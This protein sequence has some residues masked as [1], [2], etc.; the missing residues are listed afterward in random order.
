MIFMTQHRRLI[1]PKDN[2][3][4]LNGSELQYSGEVQNARDS[5]IT[6]HKKSS[7]TGSGVGSALSSTHHTPHDFG[8]DK[9]SMAMGQMTSLLDRRCE[10]PETNVDSEAKGKS[11]PID[12]NLDEAINHCSADEQSST[13]AMPQK[14]SSHARKVMIGGKTIKT[15]E[16]KSNTQGQHPTRSETSFDLEY[17]QMKWDPVDNRQA[18]IHFDEK[19]MVDAT[20]K[21]RSR[22]AVSPGEKD[23]LPAKR[24]ASANTSLPR[25][26]T[27]RPVDS[28]FSKVLQK[29]AERVTEAETAARSAHS[30]PTSAEDIAEDDSCLS[31]HDVE[32]FNDNASPER[33]TSYDRRTADQETEDMIGASDDQ[34]ASPVPDSSLFV[35][36]QLS[37]GTYD[38]LWNYL[39]VYTGPKLRPI[40]DIVINHRPGYDDIKAQIWDRTKL[41]CSKMGRV[42]CITLHKPVAFSAAALTSRI[43]HGALQEIQL[44]PSE[45]KALAVFLFPKDAKHFARHIDMIQC[46]DDP[47]YRQMQIDAEWYQE[48]ESLL[49]L[50]IQRGIYQAVIDED[51]SRVLRLDRIPVTKKREELAQELQTQLGRPLVHVALIMEPRRHVRETVGNAATIE[52]LSVKDAYESLQ[53]F[54]KGQVIGYESTP[55]TF[56]PDPC[57]RMPRKS[58]LCNCRFCQRSTTHGS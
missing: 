10:D 20:P 4:A 55:V 54:R 53:R 23:E 37:P 17:G 15:M 57:E 30:E 1:E 58:V 41:Q 22:S 46:A 3:H 38:K 44:F 12:T 51:A 36:R 47:I 39:D 50:P 19:D 7:V 52:F 24:P 45:Q 13:G 56:S 9:S 2:T 31:D 21:K 28:E 14:H 11:K 27:T 16:R 48:D 6:M 40:D 5:I 33:L 43:C 8:K 35:P 42:L 25:D 49:V 29:Y 34:G 18:V 32:D 26:S